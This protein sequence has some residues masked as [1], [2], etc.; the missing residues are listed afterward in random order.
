MY[1]IRITGQSIFDLIL[2]LLLKLGVYQPAMYS[3]ISQI[4]SNLR[5]N[6]V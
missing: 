4:M 1:S 5:L 6:I 2:K 3:K